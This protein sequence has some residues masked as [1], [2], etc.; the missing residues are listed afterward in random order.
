MAA[1]EHIATR[2]MTM[3]PLFLGVWVLGMARKNYTIIEGM[4][5]KKVKVS[6]ANFLMRK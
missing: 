3:I 1:K 5:T 6:P 4:G 2:R